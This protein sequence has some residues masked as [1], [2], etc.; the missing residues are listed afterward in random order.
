MLLKQG[1]RKDM[2]RILGPGFIALQVRDLQAS[3]RFYTEQLGLQEA[4]ASPPNAIVFATSPI[5]FALREPLVNLDEVTQLGWGVSLWLACDDAKALHAA[6]QAGG[7]RIAQS[8]FDGP[9]GQTFSFIDPDG[10]L[11]TA[12]GEK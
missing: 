5:P 8:L 12:Y 4:P 2:A 9:F 3:R 6:L 11:I 10:Y 7:T 1:E